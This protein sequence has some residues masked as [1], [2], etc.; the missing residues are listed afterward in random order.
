MG[1]VRFG[2]QAHSSSE[3]DIQLGKKKEL[4]MQNNE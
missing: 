2:L 1:K 3:N 4:K